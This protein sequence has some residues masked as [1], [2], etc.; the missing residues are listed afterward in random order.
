MYTT[1]ILVPL[2]W[3]EPFHGYVDASNVALGCVL[4]KKDSKNLDHPIYFASRQ[5]I[6]AENNYT[7]IGREALCMFF[8][9]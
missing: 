3:S 6:A 5:L 8:A 2:D 1:L 9:V 4:S 7:T